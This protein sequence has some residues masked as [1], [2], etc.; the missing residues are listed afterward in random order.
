MLDIKVENKVR[1]RLGNAHRLILEARNLAIDSDASTKE[2]DILFTQC[3]D[4]ICNI[5]DYL[6]SERTKQQ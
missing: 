3:I 6:L 2:L 4:S 1:T 5:S